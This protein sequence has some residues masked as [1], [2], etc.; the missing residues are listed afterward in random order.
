MQC[1][2]CP[3]LCLLINQPVALPHLRFTSQST[4]NTTT[5]RY[6]HTYYYPPDILGSIYGHDALVSDGAVGLKGSRRHADL[7]VHLDM[8]AVHV[9]GR[10]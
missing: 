8:W 2:G 10:Q 3:A 4:N 9:D 5:T 1:Q 6:G 7:E